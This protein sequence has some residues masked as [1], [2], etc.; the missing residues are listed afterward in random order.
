MLSFLR[1]GERLYKMFF[2]SYTRK[3]WS[4]DPSELSGTLAGRIPIRFNTDD[5]Y[6]NDPYQG[7]PVRGYTTMVTNMLDHEKKYI[8]CWDVIILV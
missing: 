7:M 4:C 3:Q 1:W 6:F 2:E 8:S 5:R